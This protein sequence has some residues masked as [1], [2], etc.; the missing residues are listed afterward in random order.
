MKACDLPDRT[1]ITLSRKR[2]GSGS[3]FPASFCIKT[4]V[5]SIT[6]SRRRFRKQDPQ[7]KFYQKFRL[8]ISSHHLDLFS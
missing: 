3:G 7:Q 2:S 4:F 5:A 8:Q 6:G 1:C